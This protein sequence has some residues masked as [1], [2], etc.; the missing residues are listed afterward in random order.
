MSDEPEFPNFDEGQVPL[1]YARPGLRPNSCWFGN[2]WLDAALHFLI[3][4]PLIIIFAGIAVVMLRG[5][6]DALR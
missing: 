6:I 2:R 1:D 4:F 5:C 3:D